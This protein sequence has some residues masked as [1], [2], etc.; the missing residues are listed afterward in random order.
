MD[1]DLQNE[2]EVLLDMYQLL[3]SDKVDVVLL[4]SGPWPKGR[5]KRFCY[6]MF[7]RLYTFL[8]DTP[9]QVDSRY[10]A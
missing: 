10:F 3:R 6:Y 7:Y 9:V 2:P 4:L 8:A 5:L 1:A